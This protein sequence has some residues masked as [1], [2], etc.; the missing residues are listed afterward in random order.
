MAKYEL[1]RAQEVL[2]TDQ[3]K[4]SLGH[5]LHLSVTPKIFI[6]FYVYYI[7]FKT[8]IRS[9]IQQNATVA[10]GPHAL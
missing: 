4:K 1:Y 2:F 5:V 8:G 6:L 10:M 7:Y 9:M 3:D